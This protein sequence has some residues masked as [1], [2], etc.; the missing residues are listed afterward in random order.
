MFTGFLEEEVMKNITGCEYDLPGDLLNWETAEWV[1]DRGDL[2]KAKNMSFNDICVDNSH[3]YV[4]VIP[5]PV[6]TYNMAMDRCH[7]LGMT[8][9]V[10]LN[11]YQHQQTFEGGNSAAMKQNCHMKG[12]L[13]VSYALRQGPRG[14]FHDPQTNLSVDYITQSNY[15]ILNYPRF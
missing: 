7:A 8:K 12:R 15:S 2:I 4:F 5:H 14:F 11:S 10:P 6:E 3:E 9:V 13:A 1:T